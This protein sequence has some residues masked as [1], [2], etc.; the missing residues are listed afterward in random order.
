MFHLEAF[1]DQCHEVV[2]SQCGDCHIDAQ[3]K[4]VEH[5]V[6]IPGNLPK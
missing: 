6:V 3:E 1:E 5:A 2:S 4:C